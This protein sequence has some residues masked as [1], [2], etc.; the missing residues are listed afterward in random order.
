MAISS[1]TIISGLSLY[2]IVIKDS[3]NI[4][5]NSNKLISQNYLISTLQNDFLNCKYLHNT[6]NKLLVI[7]DDEKLNKYYVFN[8]S[9]VVIGNITSTD[10]IN[11]NIAHLVMSFNAKKIKSGIVDQ[12]YMSIS[13]KK[14]KTN[15]I[16]NKNYDAVT[17]LSQN[18]RIN[19]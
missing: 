14:S 7:Y 8:D 19:N 10:T 15:L 11:I 13:Y 1:I 4:Q 6:N 16:I 3:A 18:K 12:L 17:L 5:F 9:Y 2:F